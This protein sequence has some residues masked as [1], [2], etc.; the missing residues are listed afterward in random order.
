MI[1]YFKCS[2]CEQFF[3]CSEKDLPHNLIC[4]EGCGGEIQE[5]DEAR[6]LDYVE[7]LRRLQNGRRDNQY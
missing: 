7:E 2:N 3:I 1:R 5:I 4:G 6:A